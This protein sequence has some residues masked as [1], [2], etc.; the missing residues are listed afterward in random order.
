MKIPRSRTSIIYPIVLV[1]LLALISL[2]SFIASSNTEEKLNSLVDSVIP[3]NDLADNLLIDLINMETG[4]RGYE[5]SGDHAFLEP[6][7]LG[8]TR[9]QLDL[10]RMT[11]FEEAY[12]QLQPIMTEK[13]LPFIQ[14]LQSYY[15]SQINLID[16]GQRE[17]ALRRIQNGK[18]YMDSFR[19]IQIELKDEIETIATDARQSARMA[20]RFARLVIGIGGVLALGVGLFSI[21]VFLRASRAESALRKSEETYRY[22]AESLEIQNEEIIAQQEEQEATLEKLS[23]REHELEAISGYQEK[24]SGSAHLEAFLRDSIPA[25]LETLKLDSAMLVLSRTAWSS[26]GEAADN[27]SAKQTDAENPLFEPVFSIG[28]P[29]KLPAVRESELYGTA[30]RVLQEKRMLESVRQLSA[31]ERG[32]HQGIEKA[33]DY[34]F[35]L[36]NDQQE[37]IGFLML[38]GYDVSSFEHRMRIAQGLIRQFGLAFMVQQANEARSRQAARLEQ[39]NLQLLQEKLLIQEQRD[40]IGNILQSTHEGMVMCDSEGR[41][42]FVNPRMLE[43]TG[44]DSP[45]GE[46]VLALGR[47]MLADSTSA[48]QVM[49]AFEELL[50]GRLHKFTERFPIETDGEQRRFVELYAT[51][52]GEASLQ[53]AQG[54]LFVIRDRT[55]EEKIDELKNEFISIVSHEL[56]TP[57]ASVLGFIE[58]LLHRQLTPDKQ[59]KY[60]QTVYKEA[61]RLSTLIND[62]LDLQ[63][64]EAGKQEYRLL[65]LELGGLL[66]EVVDQWNGKQGHK[67][68]LS[69]PGREIWVRADADRLMQVAHNLLSNATKYSPQAD[70]V[71]VSL[72]E[73][74]GTVTLRVQDYGLGIPE[75]AK[76]K[77]F[78]KFYRVDNSDRRQIG[79]TGLG[80]SIV[81]EIVESHQGTI[82]F[83]SLMGQGSVFTITLSTYQGASAD[84]GILLLEDDENLA[85]LIQ[86]GLQKMQLKTVHLRS[87]EEGLLALENSVQAPPKLCIVDIGLEGAKNGWDFIAELYRHPQLHRTPVIVSSAM[88]P[89]PEYREKVGETYLRKPFSMEKLLQVAEQLVHRSENRPAYVF[90]TEDEHLIRSSLARQGI[91]I[92]SVTHESGHIQIEPKTKP[93]NP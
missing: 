52:V 90:P 77:L 36:F 40:V 12:P 46:S 88:E 49:S 84:H 51:R 24:L 26:D 3:V 73:S 56:R 60:L 21:F 70:R 68:H 69:T 20:E 2:T 22:M 74:G 5:L 11:E 25:L 34:Y 4:L 19:Q 59:Q 42:Q 10:K 7:S 93:E 8:K 61:G 58:I 78:S 65:P 38:T 63:R 16:S 45:V 37:S 30:R 29:S 92:N 31:A 33:V 91:E 17:E 81:R 86:V 53:N 47:E 64:M 83:D 15:E 44:L 39:L 80:L 43:L 1:A 57:L 72:E 35:P 62:F 6:Y 82:T 23:E 87:A 27:E 66:H 13:A 9:L 41:I 14:N 71:D 18:T 85:K 54:Y 79:G 89:P 75:D 55:E 32:F 50:N 48:P 76:D 67:V 28:Y